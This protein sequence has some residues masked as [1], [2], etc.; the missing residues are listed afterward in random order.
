MALAPLTI[1][2]VMDQRF[3]EDELRQLVTWLESPVA[4]KYQ[5]ALPDFQR[6]L[7]DR[8]IEDTRPSVEPRLKELNATVSRKLTAAAGNAGPSAPAK[9]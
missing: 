1:G 5:Q 7:V 4:R 2:E 3:T 9:P 6:A 8:L